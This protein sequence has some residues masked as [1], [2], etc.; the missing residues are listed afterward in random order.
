MLAP[1]PVVWHNEEGKAGVVV[2][3]LVHG[4]VLVAIGGEDRCW[5]LVV[6]PEE[7][8]PYLGYWR[9]GYFGYCVRCGGDDI[10]CFCQEDGQ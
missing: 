1:F 6:K 10:F 7:E 4:G 3:S 2:T 5:V 9:E 8:V